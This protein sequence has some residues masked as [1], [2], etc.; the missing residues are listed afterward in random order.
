MELL[1]PQ[2]DT[3]GLIRDLEIRAVNPAFEAAT[4]RRAADLV[5]QGLASSFPEMDPGI[6]E[7]FCAVADGST[8]LSLNSVPLRSAIHAGTVH[9][10]DVR[11]VRLDIDL[12]L[13]TYRDVTD[14][15]QAVERLKHSENL[16]RLV[17]D[18]SNDLV[19]IVAQDTIV[20]SSPASERLLGL[21]PE[22]LIGQDWTAWIDPEHRE[23]M[24]AFRT[25]LVTTSHGTT[26]TKVMGA[27]GT[28]HWV[29]MTAGPYTDDRGHPI[30]FLITLRLIDAEV[31]AEDR[32]RALLRQRE[33]IL[34]NAPVGVF[35]LRLYPDA[36]KTDYITERGERL[37]IGRR[38]TCL[39]LRCL[40]DGTVSAAD[41]DEL[42]ARAAEAASTGGPVVCDVEGDDALGWIRITA[43]VSRDTDGNLIIDGVIEDITR[44][45]QHE[46]ALQTETLAAMDR[47]ERL[48]RQVNLEK[49]VI[50][51]LGHD[52]RTPL[53]TI[54]SSASALNSSDT[55]LTDL[56]RCELSRGIA[57]S[58]E[59]LSQLIESL[60]DLRRIETGGFTARLESTTLLAVLEAPLGRVL[61][62][63]ELD[64]PTDLPD[65]LADRALLER[66]V[67]NLIDNAVRHSPQGVPV[68]VRGRRNGDAIDLE[69][70]DSGE[71]V[72]AELYEDMFSPFRR[73][74]GTT[75]GGLGLGL[76]IAKGFAEAMGM[77][78]TPSATPGGGL[79]MTLR[80]RTTHG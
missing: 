44:L 63:I 31:A 79:T 4:G 41:V 67:E 76:P 66:S 48:Q 37:L 53:S 25:Q 40:T 50:A 64:I 22:T 47:A 59:R 42:W 73:L 71:G 70:I 36:V 77:T 18:T 39:P 62:P 80:I 38:G 68:L 15:V 43:Y 23:E 54:M 3:T 75:R 69:I 14:Q 58:A 10:F 7:S 52:L 24:G 26:R 6:F 74:N 56:E 49:S 9:F 5:G 13:V 65:L 19:L 30:G 72:P 21:L 32:T 57:A 46:V 11:A 60:I 34:T 35:R 61:V 28:R 20:W 12:L 78:L 16:Y 27:D 33:L 29:S 51:S 17:S 55:R 45:R 2:R 8:P 1:R